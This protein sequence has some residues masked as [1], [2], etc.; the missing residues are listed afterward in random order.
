MFGIALWDVFASQ[1]FRDRGLLQPDAARRYLDA[2]LRREADHGELL[3]SMVSLELW[4]RRYLDAGP[5]RAR[6]TRDG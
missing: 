2:H 1:A 5:S 4:A 6:A 3:W